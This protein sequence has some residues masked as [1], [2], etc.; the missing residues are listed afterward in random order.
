MKSTHH[1]EPGMGSLSS[2]TIAKGTA[3]LT[4]INN[5]LNDGP[6]NLPCF[7]DIVPRVRQT[8]AIPTARSRI[9]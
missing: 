9:W 1:T 7:P 4:R 8:L 6:L 2:E 5:E 3:F